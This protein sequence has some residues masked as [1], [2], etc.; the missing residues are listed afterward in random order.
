MAILKYIEHNYL[1]PLQSLPLQWY[2]SVKRGYSAI[3]TEKRKHHIVVS[4]TSFPARFNTLHLVI[5][6]ILC[7]TMKPDLIFLCLTKQEMNDKIQLPASLLELNNYGLYTFFANDNLKP[8]NKY[9]SAMQQYPESLVI[10]V[11]DDNMYDKNLVSD[12]YGS[13]LKYPSAISARRVHKILRDRNGNLLPYNKWGY[14]YKRQTAPSLDLLATGVGGAL[15]PPG[16]LP[17]ETFDTTKIME[18]C[19]NADD[20]WLKFMELKNHVPVVWAKGRRV[21]P[22]TI[23]QSQK[24][25]LNK[26]NYHENQNDTYIAALENYYS[27]RLASPPLPSS[28]SLG[29]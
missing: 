13:Y 3:N 15:Y 18:L 20:I 12:L 2:Y 19:L 7:Q 6:S 9:L 5:K 24:T 8:H 21:H 23:K 1:N 27:I 28:P 11:D 17:P 16:L 4:L 29:K 10:T 25:T 22:Y 14:E 26:S